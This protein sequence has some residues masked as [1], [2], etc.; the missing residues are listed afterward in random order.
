[1]IGAIAT[2]A[3]LAT[4]A[5]LV[6]LALGL[7]YLLRPR[8][9]RVHVPYSGL[10]QRVLAEHDTHVAGRQWRRWRS[11][12]VMIAIAGLLVAALAEPLWRDAAAQTK[13]ELPRHTAII[14]DVS[15]SMG[16]RDAGTDALTGRPRTRLDAARAK[17]REVLAAAGPDDRFALLAASGST[18]IVAGWNAARQEV[19]AAAERLAPTDAGLDLERALSLAHTALAERLGPSIV[20]VGDGGPSTEPLAERRAHVPVVHARVG[21]ANL[22][23]E[24]RPELAD[25]AVEKVRARLQPLDPGQATLTVHLR[26]AS[27]VAHRVRLLIATSSSATTAAEFVRGSAVRR[28]LEVSAAPG[29]SRHEVPDFAA[30]DDRVSV[31]V[32]ATEPGLIDVSPWNDIGFAVIVA[33]KR[34]RVLLAG[35]PHAYLKA[36]ALANPRTDVVDRSGQPYFG[37]AWRNDKPGVPFDAVILNQVGPPPVG[38]PALVI[39]L[40][41]SPTA[42]A[43]LDFVPA[44]DIVAHDPAHPLLRGVSFQDANFDIARVLALGPGDTAIADAR[45]RGPVMVAHEGP[46]RRIDWGLDLLE[47]DLPLRYAMPVLIDDALEW[48]T[49]SEAPD[50]PPLEPGRAWAIDVPSGGANWQWTEPGGAERPARVAGAQV[51]GSSERHGIHVLRSDSGQLVVRATE[52][53]ATEAP[54]LVTAGGA[55][56][57]PPP[58]VAAPEPPAARVSLWVA[59]IVAAALALAAEWPAY[60]RRRTV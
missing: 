22:P 41:P 42:N 55:A 57:R 50:V 48:L 13:S 52:L 26:N 54:E 23:P 18:Q 43:A 2:P 25:L 11:L 53:P 7:L 6:A 20:I 21:R 28:T 38:I 58:A 44:P 17:V 16:T 9:R 47:T 46:V 3:D 10:W 1:V 51:I 39:A 14:V 45:G 33:R 30:S 37:E 49:A 8:R 12:L 15:A 24:K 60:L 36:A 5:G 34:L 56:W 35:Q 59:L 29:R 31:R 27:P 19:V 32:E 40:R 4:V